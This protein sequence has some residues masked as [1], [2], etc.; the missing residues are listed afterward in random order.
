MFLTAIRPNKAKA[1]RSFEDTIAMLDGSGVTTNSGVYVNSDTAMRQATVYACVRVISE[2]IAQLPI[3]VQ[4]KNGE[5]WQE[6]PDHDLI[7]LLSEPNE[8]QTQHDLIS[9]LVSWSELAGNGY[10]FKIRNGVGA[11]R[12]LIPIESRNTDVNIKKDM[13]LEYTITSE[14]GING[15][16]GKDRIFHLRN[17]GTQGYIGLST[18][19]NHREGIGLGLQLESHAVAAY[20]NGLQ[21]NKWVKL[22]R[23]LNGEQLEKFKLLMAEYQGAMRAGK[24]PYMSDAEIHEFKGISPTDAQYIESKKMQKEE[25]ATLFLVPMFI[26]NSTENTTWGSGL[27]QISRSFVRF[28]LNPR[29]NRISQTLLREL[30]PEKD[31]KTT[32][33]VFDTDNFTLGEFKTRMDG[34]RSA[35]E[36]GVLN[37]NECREIERRNAR[38][39]G[40]EY[41]IPTNTAIEGEE[42][43]IQDA[44][45]PV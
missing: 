24:M 8:W 4:V 10:L 20:K 35:I 9:T 25:I 33:I 6:V 1:A 19:A 12:G 2:T 40:D 3:E 15:T 45:P 13:S 27:E 14:H 31:R 29:L 37:P 17:F 32:R 5:N 28:S 41:R 39:G 7:G 16:Y 11:V 44:K 42:N 21:T 22:D 18:I 36:S 30:I 38:E 43:A 26:L 34:Y 23:A